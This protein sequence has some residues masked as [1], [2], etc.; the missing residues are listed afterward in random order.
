MVDIEGGA[1][2]TTITTTC[3]GDGC[4]GRRSDKGKLE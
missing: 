4:G 3:G 1:Q 2:M